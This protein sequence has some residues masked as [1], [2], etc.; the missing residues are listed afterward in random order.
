MVR[1]ISIFL[2]LFVATA[3]L[4]A[5]AF[6]RNAVTA[7][8]VAAHPD[9]ITRF[10]M[11]ITDSM[12]YRVRLLAD[13]D[14]VVVDTDG[15][16]VAAQAELRKAVGVISG[17]HYAEDAAGGHL[18][19]SLRHPAE[20]KSAFVITPRDNL[21]WRFVM[22][23]RDISPQ[24]FQAAAASRPARPLAAANPSPP[25]APPVPAAAPRAMVTM[26][27]P[28][29]PTAV[30]FSGDTA[31]KSIVVMSPAMEEPPAVA[32][33]P[34]V[35]E[36]PAGN[37]LL[38]SSPPQTQAP[39]AIVAVPAV[40]SPV[41]VASVAPTPQPRPNRAVVPML[42][43]PMPP[44]PER[45]SVTPVAAPVPLPES[46]PVAPNSLPI[47]KVAVPIP[48]PDPDGKPRHSDGRPVIVIDPGHGGVDPGA[49]SV[50][51]IYEKYITLAVARDLK[52]HMERTGR[53]HVYLTR[54]RDVFIRLRDRVAIARQDGADLFISLHA[55]VV[56]DPEIRGLS[57]YTLSQNASSAEAQALADK[58]N[59]A[60]LIAGIDLSHES[61]DVA[62]IL[63]DLAQRETMNRSA[64][65]AS[66]IVDELG[67]ET[68]LLENSHRFA[69]FA[70]LKAPDVPA[71]LIEAG[72]LSN[73]VEERNLRQPEYR[74]KLARAITRAVDHFFV[75]GQKAKR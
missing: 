60:D 62:N 55:D 35:V 36:P 1:R 3:L 66:G 45:P 25:V 10:V 12:E 50:S 39:V 26:A 44:P 51:G 53:Y 8:R 47:T 73:E 7:T 72:Y 58:E 70:V 61:A 68:D 48:A 56:K 46:L 22:D 4:P 16:A 28:S 40:A 49:T 31:P 2:I 18:V 74:G 67:R 69:G 21:G 19:L 11:D 17:M 41:V 42:S 23:L 57:V 54:D 27:G 71:V 9:G 14:R 6:A 34:L 30:G 38:T 29:A 63:I 32:P 59:K 5:G 15:M 24:A 20:V 64:A 52:D 75:P 13:P 43:A 33:L 37:P 65:F